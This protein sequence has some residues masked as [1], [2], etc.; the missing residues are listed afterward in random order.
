MT[1]A[2]KPEELIGEVLGRPATE[3][4]DPAETEFGCPF[5]EKRCIKATG[6]N[7][8]P[9]CSIW[10]GGRVV[11]ICPN[12][13]RQRSIVDDVIKQCW[14][15]KSAQSCAV[16]KEVQM[17]GF[18]NVDFVVTEMQDGLVKD[19]ISVEAQTVDITGSYR[20]AY[21]AWLENAD[22]EKSPSF[23]L[24]WDNVYKRYVTQL[25]RKGFYHHHWDTKIVAL[26]QDEVFKYIHGKFP[27]LTTPNINDPA[28]NVVFLLYRYGNG[29]N[30]WSL[31]FDCCV[32]TSHANLSQAALYA[33]APERA[34]FEGKIIESLGR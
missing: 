2:I 34:A 26:M 24:N 29:V 1:V 12:R 4:F 13:L 7:P 18:G 19:F 23:G 8:M 11:A 31:E 5:T 20:I 33:K 9:V 25:I 21:S 27:F 10:R 14:S 28:A 32:G 16:A 22:L 30:R 17:Q 6:A 15:S 3:R